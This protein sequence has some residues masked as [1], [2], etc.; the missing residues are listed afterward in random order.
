MS[1]RAK[2]DGAYNIRRALRHATPAHTS[3]QRDPVPLAGTGPGT[4]MLI[5]AVVGE[6]CT[7]PVELPSFE[8]E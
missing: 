1:S 8:V 2:T 3:G 5:A 6:F 7:V 4:Y